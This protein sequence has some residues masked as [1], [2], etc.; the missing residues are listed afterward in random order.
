[1]RREGYTREHNGRQEGHFMVASF[2]S[3]QNPS[4]FRKRKMG[5]L[6]PL[7]PLTMQ[8]LSAIHN[9]EGF[10]K[11]D[12]FKKM[13]PTNNAPLGFGKIAKRD[14]GVSYTRWN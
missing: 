6:G 14:T 2:R 12:Y 10:F 13:T 5:L 1:M 3:S 7:P 4:F 8:P 9:N 11:N